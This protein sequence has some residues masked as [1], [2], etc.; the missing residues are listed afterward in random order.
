M[1]KIWEIPLNFLRDYTIPM[2][3]FEEWDRTRATV[4]PLTVPIS[5]CF[6][7]SLLE[8]ETGSILLIVCGALAGP[9]ILCSIYL[10][11]C[12]KKT[13][14][15]ERIMFVMAIVGFVQAI[16]WISFTSDFVIDLLWIIGLILGI[17]KSV[18]GLT[19]LAVGNCLGDM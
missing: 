9:G 8:G 5:F 18:L 17:P 6:L 3:E 4:L 19:L 14:A 1:C 11:F 10:A 15:P 2:A 7:F 13:V 16:V 12:T